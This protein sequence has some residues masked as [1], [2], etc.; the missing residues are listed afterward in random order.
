MYAAMPVIDDTIREES[1]TGDRSNWPSRDEIDDEYYRAAAEDEGDYVS[2]SVYPGMLLF[3]TPTVVRAPANICRPS[4]RYR[5][6][7]DT[8]LAIL[9]TFTSQHYYFYKHQDR[10]VSQQRGAVA[11]KV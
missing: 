8:H 7:T 1:Q 5:N 2:G 4:R 3:N 10:P 9:Y 11:R 6:T